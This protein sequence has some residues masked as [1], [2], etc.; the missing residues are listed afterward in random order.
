MWYRQDLKAR[1]K[2]VFQRNYWMTVLVTF[3]WSFI[4]S[5]GASFST[6]Y[7]KIKD[8][9]SSH[10]LYLDER[11][12]GMLIIVIVVGVIISIVTVALKVFLFNP[13]I[14]GCNRFYMENRIMPSRIE[15]LSYVFKTGCYWNVV[16]TMFMMDLFVFLWTLLFVVPGIIKGYEYFMIPYILS[17]NPAMDYKRAF[18]ISKKTM[19]GQKGEAFI[20]DL[21]FIGWNFLGVCTCGILSVFWVSPYIKST[22]AE[23]YAVLR[24]HSFYNQYAFSNELPGYGMR[25]TPYTMNNSSVF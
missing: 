17:E 8:Q 15:A 10:H 1:G 4:A 5:G 24:D 20:L 2:D 13:L 12:M 9:S 22:H 3:I 11:I 16:K 25:P 23:L 19:K 21:S 6:T 18:E 7:G 14:V